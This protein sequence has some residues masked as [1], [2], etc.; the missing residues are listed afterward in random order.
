[1]VKDWLRNSLKSESIEDY[2]DIQT[3]DALDE[4]DIK[5]AIAPPAPP[6]V[7]GG[8]PGIVSPAAG[9]VGAPAPQPGGV[10]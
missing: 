2:C 6:M 10:L 5:T 4:Q 8:V 7:P 1:M 9:P 3:I